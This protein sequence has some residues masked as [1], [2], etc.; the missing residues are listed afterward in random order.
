MARPTIADLA[1]Q[2]G[3]STA[4]VD[5]VLN[6]RENVRDETVRRVHQAA[7]DIGYHA[8]NIIRHRMLA[9]QPGLRLGLVLHKPKQSFYQEVSAV[10]EQQARATMQ[11]RV[12]IVPRFVESTQP[13]ELAD[14]LLS[15]KG[16]VDAIAATGVDHHLVTQAVQ[17][18]RSAKIPVFSLLS[19]FAQGVREGYFG[20]NN[21]KVGRMAG[22]FISSLAQQSGKVGTF[23]GG[24]RFHGHELRETGFRSFFRDHAPDFQILDTQINLETRKLTYEATIDLLTRHED[25]AGLYIAGGG[26]EGAIEAVRELSPVSRP[27]LIVNELTPESQ[28]GLQE[29]I[30]SIVVGTPIKAVV[31]E[32]IAMAIA[33]ANNGLSQIPGQRFFPCEIWTPESDLLR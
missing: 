4:T 7:E 31:D 12:Q 18:L 17:E 14:V 26:M 13:S 15:L 10:F 20:T 8:A 28:A 16:R 23:I 22:W 33:I 2:A 25:L 3:V 19:D 29:R 21:L 1:K 27:V 6:G 9:D 32:V 24:S 5:R 30:V 11:C